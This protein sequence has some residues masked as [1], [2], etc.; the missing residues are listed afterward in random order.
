MCSDFN[1]GSGL[2]N[3]VLN[4]RDTN[5]FTRTFLDWCVVESTVENL[6][7]KQKDTFTFINNN[8]TLKEEEVT[9]T[10]M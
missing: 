3:I 1:I 6:N 9:A 10:Y 4:P 2:Y 5:G 8:L 7:F